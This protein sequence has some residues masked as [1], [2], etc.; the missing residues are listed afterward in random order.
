MDHD[1]SNQTRLTHNDFD[2]E[3]P[4]F[5]PDG[6]LIAT[7]SGKNRERRQIYKMNAD[8]SDHAPLTAMEA[9]Q[10]YPTWSTDGSKIFFDSTMDGGGIYSIN[11]DGSDLKKVTDKGMGSFINVAPDGSKI[12]FTGMKAGEEKPHL[13]TMDMKGNN[14]VKITDTKFEEIAPT[15]NPASFKGA[16]TNNGKI[17]KIV[18][19]SNRDGNSE[20]Y[21]IHADGTNERRLTENNYYDGFPSWS[22]DGSEILFQSDRSGEAAIYVM[23]ADGSHIQQIPNTQG[24]NYAKW[25]PD[26]SKIAFFAPREGNTEIILINPDGSGALNL[27]DNAATDE[28]PSWTKDGTKIAFQTNRGAQPPPSGEEEARLNYGIYIM[29]TDGTDQTQIT[30]FETNDENPSIS[31]SG[32]QVVYQSYINDGLAIVVINTDGTNKTILTVADPPCGSPAW[33]GDGKKI[34]YDSMADGNFEIFSM[35]VDGTNKRQLTFTEG[36]TENS[37]ASWTH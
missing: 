16:P 25:S 20:I 8:G 30:D 10:G 31:P 12:L 5:S 27:S 2:D 4:H 28:T 18:F 21:S 19:H 6:R 7:E 32:E 9:Y 35:D 26:G 13:Y 3:A 22:P 23:D 17:Q 33:S 24:G 34:A 36:E 29:N 1:G 11:V 14:W 15:W 37:G